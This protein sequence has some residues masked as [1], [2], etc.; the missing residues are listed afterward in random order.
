[1][2][3]HAYDNMVQYAYDNIRPLA[4][5]ALPC[6]PRHRA[7]PAPGAATPFIRTLTLLFGTLT[8]L[9]GTL[10]LLF[11]TLSLLFPRQR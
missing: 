10:T 8:L 2:V 7:K 5:R 11:G 6:R 9:F 3:Q 1:M 4:V